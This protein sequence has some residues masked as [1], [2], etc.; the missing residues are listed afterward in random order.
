M[1]NAQIVMHTKAPASTIDD[2]PRNLHTQL[3]TV[4]SKPSIPI[5]FCSTVNSGH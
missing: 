2:Q 1:F 5:Y 4:Q 3:I